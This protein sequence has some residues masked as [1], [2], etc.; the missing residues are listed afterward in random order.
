MLTKRSKTG[1]WDGDSGRREHDH[2]WDRDHGRRDHD[3]H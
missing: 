3:R 1:Y 2:G